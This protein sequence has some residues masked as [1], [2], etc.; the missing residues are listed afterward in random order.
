MVNYPARQQA[1]SKGRS[2][3]KI[4]PKLLSLAT[5]LLA[6]A[7]PSLSH[8]QTT[9]T[10]GSSLCG[11]GSTTWID[12]YNMPITAN[13][14]T[15]TAWIE[16]DY[17]ANAEDFLTGRS[18]SPLGDYITSDV[19]ITS[20]IAYQGAQYPTEVKATLT[21]VNPTTGQENGSTGKLDLKLAYT[22]CKV[23]RW[24]TGL[25]SNTAGGT[26]IVSEPL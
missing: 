20:S 23:S 22:L 12:C 11:T 17:H 24:A 9:L 21:G 19:Q 6:M 16:M 26:V 5:A 10:I 2:T 8:A 13:G 25:C 4:I 18:P 15:T 14:Q 3:M 1:K 7:L